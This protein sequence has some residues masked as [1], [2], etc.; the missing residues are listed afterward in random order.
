VN[1]SSS[2]IT[3]GVVSAL[4]AAGV[5]AMPDDG[6]LVGIFIKSVLTLGVAGILAWQVW[7]LMTREMPR[8]RE[9]HKGEREEQAKAFKEAL[10]DVVKDHRTERDSLRA[11]RHQAVQAI[12]QNTRATE[13]LASAVERMTGS[14]T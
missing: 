2:I 7:W 5:A 10:T 11:E 6:G 14:E 9:E 12:E 8:M 3:A 4:G 1:I 13:R